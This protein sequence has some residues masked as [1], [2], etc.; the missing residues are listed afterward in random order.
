MLCNVM[1]GGGVLFRLFQHCKGVPSNG[2]N[3]TRGW[4][5]LNFQKKALHNT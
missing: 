4:G 2:I 1:E 3:V 5:V